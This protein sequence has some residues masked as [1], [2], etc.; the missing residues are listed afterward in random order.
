[1]SWRKVAPKL[2]VGHLP[3]VPDPAPQG[4]HTHGG[5]GGRAPRHLDAGPHPRI[6]G[7]GTGEVDQLHAPLHQSEPHQV[8]VGG[9]GQHVDQGVAHGH[10]VEKA[11]V[12]GALAPLVVGVGHGPGTYCLSPPPT[13]PASGALG[14]ALVAC[15]GDDHSRGLDQH[16][17]LRRPPAPLHGRAGTLRDPPRSR[18]GGRHLQR[19]RSAS[20]PPPMTGSPP[21]PS[22]APSWPSPPA[23]VDERRHRRARHGHGGRGDRTDPPH[24]GLARRPRTALHRDLLH[25]HPERQAPR[26]L[27]LDLHRCGGDRPRPGHHPVRGDRRPPGLPLLRRARP[28]GRLQPDPRRRPRSRR[29]LQRARCSHSPPSPATGDAS[30]SPT[31]WSCRPTSWPSSSASW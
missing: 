14:E 24:P 17:S 1:M 18:S 12:P 23:E 28:Q 13:S 29:L 8:V 16:R 10:D 4:G 11:V 3:D 26:L 7:D 31:P 9:T 20:R 15:T 25:R 5:V 21:S 30:A 27:P 6:D 22:T 2:V 19:A